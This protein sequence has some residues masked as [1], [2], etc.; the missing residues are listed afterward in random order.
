M[1]HVQCHTVCDVLLPCS[2]LYYTLLV[3]VSGSGGLK[4]L[5]MNFN[6]PGSPLLCAIPCLFYFHLLRHSCTVCC[7]IYLL[8]LPVIFHVYDL[9][10][11]FGQELDNNM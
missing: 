3:L 10:S 5:I 9:V 7:R 1:H 6:T 4:V 11:G 2:I 8:Y